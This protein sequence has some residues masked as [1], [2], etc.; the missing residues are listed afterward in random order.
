MQDIF[1]LRYKE[2]NKNKTYN[3]ACIKEDDSIVFDD[4]NIILEDKTADDE[5]I[6][7]LENIA[8]LNCIAV[9]S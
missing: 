9:L 2:E 5:S 4:I 8:I 3:Y 1:L 6:L 7:A